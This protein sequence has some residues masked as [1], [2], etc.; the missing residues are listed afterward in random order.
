MNNLLGAAK[1]AFWIL[2]IDKSLIYCIQWEKMMEASLATLKLDGT[3]TLGTNFVL[4]K[5]NHFPDAST[6]H[7]LIHSWSC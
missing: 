7:L 2:A 1:V 5:S 4:L 6:E 3:C